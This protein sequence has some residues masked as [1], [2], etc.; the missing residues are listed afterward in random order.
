MFSVKEFGN[1]SLVSVIDRIIDYADSINMTK[2]IEDIHSG[3]R[4]DVPLF[5][6]DCFNEAVKNAFIHNNWLRR[7]APM[8]TFFEDRI[9]ITS[10]SSLAPKQTIE[11]FYKGYSIP[12]NE[13]LSSIFLATHLS[14]RTGKG[15]P[16]I[17]S[18]YGRKAFKINEDSIIVT[19]P[20]NW[21]RSFKDLVDNAVDKLADKL[22]KTE[23][24]ILYA[25]KENPK[26][27]QIGIAKITNTGKTTVQ[28]TIVKLKHLSL[29][30]RIGSNKTGYWQIID[31]NDY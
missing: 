17:V 23:L 15:N 11:G 24:K 21:I 4:T 12:V 29:I 9:E 3:T 6:Q 10:F 1:Q 25:I 18:N 28:N 16:L 20:Y 14:E 30:K 27:S 8:I 19:I 22:N 13:D 2:S 7:V 26:M 31:N 5:N